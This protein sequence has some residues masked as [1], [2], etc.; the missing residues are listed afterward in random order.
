MNLFSRL[1][2]STFLA[3]IWISLLVSLLVIGLRESGKLQFLELAAYDLFLSFRSHDL[4]T[5]SPITLVAI[6]EADIQKLGTWPLTDATLARLLNRLEE[7]QPRVIGLDIYRDLPVPPGKEDLIDVFSQNQNIVT[8]RK[9]GGGASHGV[10]APYVESAYVGFCDIPMDADKVTRRGLLFLESEGQV[11]YSFSLLMA[12][13][14]L[15]EVGITPQP[16]IPNP[17]HLRLGDITFQPFEPNDGSYVDADAG[18]YQFIL[19]YRGG[20]A[21]F[22]T[23]ALTDVLEGRAS[24]ARIKDRI[25]IIGVS[26]ESVKDEFLS[27]LNRFSNTTFYGVEIHAHLAAQ[28]LRSALKNAPLLRFMKDSQENGWL[29]LWGLLGGMLG[30][31]IRSFWRFSLAGLGGLFILMLLAWISFRSGWWIPVVPP[32]LAWL[33]SAALVTAHI[34]HREKADRTLLM[35]LFSRHVSEDIAESIWNQRDTFLDHGRP[36]P[37]KLIAT[38][39]FTDLKGFTS[40]SEKMD[41]QSLLDWLNEYMGAM[42]QIVSA[43][44]GVVL[45]FIGDAIMAV[46][47]VPIARTSEEERKRDAKNAVR[48]GLAMGEELR[49]LNRVWEEKGLPRTMMRVGVYTGPMVAGSLGCSR[50]MEY[51][52]YGDTVNIASRLENYAKESADLDFEKRPCRVLIGDATLKCLDNSFLTERVGEVALKGKEN[53]VEV[54]RVL[55][56]KK[57]LFT[58]DRVWK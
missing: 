42:T 57:S 50:R 32:A 5:E 51:T 14:Y 26:A 38:V 23:V 7:H 43:H 19:D 4:P 33:G 1:I 21:P 22:A 24:P 56:E 12:L 8:I 2:R 29:L 40:V 49:R 58:G 54:F 11:H 6:T 41:P 10:S 16:G 53:K 48:C 45:R 37:Q 39:M 17:E 15:S 46:F 47:G 25:V 20:M 9:I 3:F 36:K 44:D 28:L 34:S 18:G 13:L 35:Q 55:K 30:L 52:I 27:P 31:W